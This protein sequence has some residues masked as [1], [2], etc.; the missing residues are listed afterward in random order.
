MMLD[1]C[2]NLKRMMNENEFMAVPGVYDA[3]SAQLAQQAGFPVLYVGSYATAA[4]AFGLADVGAVTMSEMA[5]HAGRI[6][7]AVKVPVIADAENGFYQ[8]ANI[9]RTVQSFEQAG[10]AGIHIE[11]HEFGK[12]L[13]APQVFLPKEQMSEKI[14][15]AVEAKKNPNFSI[16]AR[17]D[18]FWAMRDEKEAVERVNAYAEAGADMVFLAGATPADLKKFRKDINS[19]VVITDSSGYTAEDEKASGAN[20]VLYYGF[21]LYAAYAGVKD[22]LNKWKM[23][24]S[25]KSMVPLLDQPEDFEKFIGFE[26]FVNRAKRYK[27]F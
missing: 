27:M 5:N 13:N 24:Q 2:T 18:T 3:L 26:E 23:N 20:L 17:T 16:I 19:K 15:A 22:A 6:A 21:S 7:Q 14:R 12:H 10:V 1:H 8:A 4:S 25:D 11:D 9:W